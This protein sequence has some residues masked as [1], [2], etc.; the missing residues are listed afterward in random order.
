M[1]LGLHFEIN[2]SYWLSQQTC[3]QFAT[4]GRTGFIQQKIGY[5][6]TLQKYY[7]NIILFSEYDSYCRLGLQKAKTTNKTRATR[8]AYRHRKEE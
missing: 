6:T 1:L 3:D 2:A 5:N 8:F 4:K 7:C